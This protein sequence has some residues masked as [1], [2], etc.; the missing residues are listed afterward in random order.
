MAGESCKNFVIP[1]KIKIKVVEIQYKRFRKNLTN[2]EC[3][4]VLFSSGSITTNN[5]SKAINPQNEIKRKSNK[6]KSFEVDI[7]GN[8]IE[9]QKLNM[10]RKMWVGIK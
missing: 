8:C 4:Y 5:N 10:S 3:L 9:A 1:L 2:L 6:I 7:Y